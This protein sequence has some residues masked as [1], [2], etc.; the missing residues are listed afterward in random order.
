MTNLTVKYGETTLSVEAGTSLD[1]IKAS[2]AKIFPE[3]KNAEAV[4][5]GN[6][7][8]FKVK[9]GTKGAGDVA[10]LTVV[11]GETT[12]K[13]PAGTS[14]DAV[15]ASMSKIFPELKNAQAVLNGSVVE[16]KV[17]AGTKG[18]GLTV[19]YGETRLAVEAGTNLDA[20]KASMSK[21]FPEL[22]NAEAVLSGSEVHF[23]V[24]A[25]T[26]GSG[27]TV[28]YGET[29]LA[30]EAGTSL[31]SI[32]A[33]MAKIFPEL[34]NSEAVLSGSE[35]HFRVKAGTKGNG[36]TVVYGETRLAV[37]AGTSLDSI[38]ASM[39]KIF[40]ELKN[41]EAVLNGSEIHFKVKAGTKGNGLTVVYG[42]TRLAVE[43]GTSLDSIKASM[44]K[45]FPELKNAE[46]VL[47]GSEI[48][49]KVKAGTKGNDGLTVVYGETR[50][51]VEAG[52]SLDAVKASMSKIFP[53]LKNSEAV[54]SGSEIHFK[55][56][57]GTKGVK[58]AK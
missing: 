47:N 41:A 52:T 16:F 54:L 14:L 11:Y 40:P 50:L 20:I 24:K 5:N 27:L 31:D 7:V 25:G 44:S 48:H 1:N 28:V 6:V 42:E 38:K 19:V 32:K 43:A 22:K 12:L 34:K 58:L 53:E 46:A 29:R 8:E 18:S 23:K 3:L 37:E 39:S 4:L 51:A 10:E 13:V 36:L 17:K 9:A 2:M 55:V 57:A 33:S 45:I 15:K 26:K 56:K 35:V 30:V 49:F 21:I